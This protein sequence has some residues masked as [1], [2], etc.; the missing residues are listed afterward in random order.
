[1]DLH[2]LPAAEGQSLSQV[3]GVVHSKPRRDSGKQSLEECVQNGPSIL[4]E[5]QILFS[6]GIALVELLETMRFGNSEF[7]QKR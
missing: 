7:S 2:A 6:L 1:M 5:L 4:G 3:V